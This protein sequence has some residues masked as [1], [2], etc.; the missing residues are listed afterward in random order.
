MGGVVGRFGTPVTYE[1]CSE[2]NVNI[3][4]NAETAADFATAVKADRDI[5]ITLQNDMEVAISSLGEQTGGSGE[6]KLGGE[7]TKKITIDLNDKKLNITT[8]YWSAIGANNNDAVF[9]IKNGTMTSTGNSAGT[10]NAWDLRFSN[11][12]YVFEDVTFEKA[13]A[14]DNAGKS[15]KMTGV[16]ITDAREGDTYGL[17]ITAEGQTVTLEEC[18]IDM[19]PATD[20]RGIKID[21]Q[22]VDAPAKVTLNVN[23]VTFKTEEK[24]AVVVKSVAGAEINWGEDN[25]IKAVAADSDFAVWVDEDAKAHAA[26]VVVNGANV[27]V[28]G[29]IVEIKEADTIEELKQ[30][31]IDAGSAGAGHTIINL[32]KGEYTMPADWT[33]IKVDGYHG[34]DIVTLN[35]NGA[36]LKGLTKSLF[37]GGFAGGSGIVIKDLTIDGANIVATHSG[38]GD[39]AFINAADSMNEIT[40]INCHLLNSTIITPNDGLDSARIGGLV[41]W[42]SGYSNQNDGPV[43]TYVNIKECSVVGCTLK[44]AGS[45]GAICGHAGSSDWTW[46]TIENC[47]VEDN[48]LISTDEGSWRVGVAV[49]TANIGHVIINNL[50]ESGNTLTQDDKVA[51]TGKRSYVGRFALGSTGSCT[52]D[53]DSYTE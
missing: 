17:W 22:Y 28:E 3:A 36:V 30:Q 31:L 20:G 19:T 26:K 37:D 1:N 5:M 12:N 48:N 40:L 34:A 52:I 23:G 39:G 33:P 7:N 42:T 2:K 24:A 35:G 21:E 38:T 14:L 25:N 13:V 44:G 8:T 53:G 11:C 46:T 10:W 6:Y 50:T 18:V 32:A 41:G 43:K 16:T 9:T 27:K 49:G 47:R 4:V 29:T 45:I 51:P 15:T